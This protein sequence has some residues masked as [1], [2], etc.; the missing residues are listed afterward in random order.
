M[1]VFDVPAIP[2]L[3]GP[4]ARIFLKIAGSWAETNLAEPA[5][6]C[7]VIV[8]RPE[9]CGRRLFLETCHSRALWNVSD[10]DHFLGF[11]L[12]R[13]AFTLG[14]ELLASSSTTRHAVCLQRGLSRSEE[15]AVLGPLAYYPMPRLQFS[16]PVQAVSVR[17]FLNPGW[18]HRLE[19]H[20]DN[21]TRR[22]RVAVR[23]PPAPL[24]CN[25]APQPSSG[26]FPSSA[27][28]LGIRNPH[29]A[30]PPPPH[31]GAAAGTYGRPCQ[32]VQPPCW[33][34]A[35]DT[36]A[37]DAAAPEVASLPSASSAVPFRLA[38]E[39]RLSA[40][41][42]KQ[43]FHRKSALCFYPDLAMPQGWLVGYMEFHMDALDVQ[44]FMSFVCFFGMALPLICMLTVLLHMNKHN[45]YKQQIQ[46]VR[47]LYQRQ[48][49]DQ[50]LAS[51][52]GGSSSSTAAAMPAQPEQ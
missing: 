28:A 48:Q 25:W 39:L 17:T 42:R 37:L 41:A 11:E 19:L 20:C 51:L 43:L 52:E 7:V 44:A 50:E 21:C 3:E 34:Y 15:P 33:G 5:T 1:T 26:T 35:D 36:Q 8:D 40:G 2:E 12:P 46:E 38:S 45:R 6:P 31:P 47:L 18:H 9:A 32:A 22:S 27:Q 16:E 29:L 10:L 49:L 4:G 23:P 13:P 24:A 14:L 30:G